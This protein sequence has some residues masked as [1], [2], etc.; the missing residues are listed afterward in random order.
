MTLANGTIISGDLIIGAD[1]ERSMVKKAFNDPETLK[2]AKYRIFRTLVP[3][4]SLMGEEGTR[5]M[6]EV[7]RGN[8]CMFLEGK[9][10]MFWF[11]GR[12]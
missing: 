5:N 1:G 7:T 10:T 2:T 4:K 8:F 9:K 12:E 3:T 11:E 6:L